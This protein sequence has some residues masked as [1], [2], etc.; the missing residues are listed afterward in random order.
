MIILQLEKVDTTGLRRKDLTEPRKATNRAAAELWHESFMERHFAPNNVNRYRLQRRHRIYLRTMK[1]EQG[2][3][4]GKS[5]LLAFSG[6]SE[7]AAKFLATI[8]ASSRQGTVR[9]SMPKYFVRPFVGTIERRFTDKEGNVRV[10]RHVV[11]RQP[12]KVRELTATT[13]IERRAIART[14]RDK[15][16]ELVHQRRAAI[17]EQL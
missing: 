13:N 15:F 5:V 2:A 3:G 9:M 7:R 12:D 4:K 17:A 10:R 8:T 1:R 16:V 14:S 6:R 11:R